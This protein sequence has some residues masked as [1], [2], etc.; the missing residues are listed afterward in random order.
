MPGG[1]F[2]RMQGAVKERINKTTFKVELDNGKVIFAYKASKFRVLKG[3]GKGTRN[4]SI[5]VGDKVKIDIP[6]K[7]L[8]KGMVVG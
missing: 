6:E 5:M 1:N 2:I 7:D 3:N 8:T 4:P